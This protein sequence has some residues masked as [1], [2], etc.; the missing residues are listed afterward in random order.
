VL[1]VQSHRV[2]AGNT[3]S[4]VGETVTVF[5]TGQGMGQYDE[6]TYAEYSSEI[7]LTPSESLTVRA[8]RPEIW[9]SNG[10]SGFLAV[11]R[12]EHLGYLGA[13]AGMVDGSGNMTPL[14]SDRHLQAPIVLAAGQKYLLQ[15]RVW[16]TMSVGIFTTG[17]RTTGVVGR[18]TDAVDSA[19]IVDRGAIACQMLR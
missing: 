1:W 5:D 16:T 8:I 14:F 6:M 12:D 2:A 19:T 13:E 15:M 7:A 11:I 17:A 3:Q 18:G 9:Y 10:T 4:V